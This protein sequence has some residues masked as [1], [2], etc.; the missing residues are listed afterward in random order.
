MG[1]DSVTGLSLIGKIAQAF[2]VQLGTNELLMLSTIAGITKRL[3]GGRDER[4]SESVRIPLRTVPEARIDMVMF[5]GAGGTALMLAPWAST[6]LVEGANI[7]AMHPPGHGSDRRPAIRRMSEVVDLYLKTLVP[8]ERPLVLVG[9]SIG[10]LVA[11]AVA[12]ALERMGTPP[13]A[14][15][16]SHTLPPP[17]WREKMFSRDKRFEEIF[18]RLY[19]A[20]GIAS[21]SRATFLESARADF[22]LAE[23]FEIPDTKLS[24]LACIISSAA[25]EFAPAR[26]LSAWDELCARPAHYPAEGGHWDFIEHPSNRDLLRS[27]Y[28]RACQHGNT[29]LRLRRVQ[30]EGALD[31]LWIPEP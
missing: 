27:V 15:I 23:S 5:P 19:E 1:M 8:A 20:W 25:D 18:D 28:T 17:I 3:E 21:Q 4:A 12:H 31:R 24:A 30:A 10:G 22:E 7:S 16:I 29:T 6:D 9:W 2:N 14:L 26:Q 11:Y 13:R